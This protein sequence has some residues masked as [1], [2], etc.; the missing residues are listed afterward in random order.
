MNEQ[1]IVLLKDNP[2]ICGMITEAKNG[3][4]QWKDNKAFH[5]LNKEEKSLYFIFLGREEVEFF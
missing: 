2:I 5:E 4:Y 3:E 1:I